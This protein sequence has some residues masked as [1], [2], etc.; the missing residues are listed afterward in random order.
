MET[1]IKLGKVSHEKGTTTVTRAEVYDAHPAHDG[2]LKF[3]LSFILTSNDSDL[4][5]DHVSATPFYTDNYT[6]KTRTGTYIDPYHLRN[7]LE[8]VIQ[9]LNDEVYL[10]DEG[11]L[12][13]DGQFWNEK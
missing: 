7:A 2:E 9:H 13:C 3:F 11:M 8:M 6:V 1:F 12:M 10:L 5:F 4:Y